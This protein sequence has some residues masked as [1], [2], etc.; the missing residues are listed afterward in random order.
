[1]ALSGGRVERFLRGMIRSGN[2]IVILP[3]GYRLELGDGTGPAIVA[4]V[5]DTLTL[6]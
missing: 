1:M 3:G 6:A 5:T 4:R 2:L